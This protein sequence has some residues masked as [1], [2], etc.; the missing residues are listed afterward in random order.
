MTLNNANPNQHNHYPLLTEVHVTR[1]ALTLAEVKL[2][3]SLLR[4]RK[5]G[6][7]ADALLGRE[8]ANPGALLSDFEEIIDRNS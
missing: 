4:E 6:A 3:A 2:L 5:G 1:Y 8:G 7:A